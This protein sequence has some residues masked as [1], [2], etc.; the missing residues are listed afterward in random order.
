MSS[1]EN[2]IQSSPK[3]AI[4]TDI[5]ARYNYAE[6]RSTLLGAVR[7]GCP[8]WLAQDAEDIAQNA[9][10]KLHQKIQQSP[11]ME[12]SKTYL[13]RVAHSV[14]VDEIRFRRRRFEGHQDDAMSEDYEIET[15]R[16]S[17]D[18]GTVGEALQDCLLRQEHVRRR[19]LTLHLLGHTI[20]EVAQ[21]MDSKRKQTENLIYRSLAGLRD[22][23]ISKG[24]YP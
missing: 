12:I 18:Q 11:D 2:S 21:L 19:V 17:P 1:R 4:E 16:E 22:C 20:A 5:N 23:L 7:M 9:I 8:G 14:L 10:I 13:R 24:V 15:R 3:T 6:L